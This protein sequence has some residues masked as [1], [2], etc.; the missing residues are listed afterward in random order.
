MPYGGGSVATSSGPQ[1]S[2]STVATFPW[3]PETGNADLMLQNIN[4]GTFPALGMSTS[5]GWNE[6]FLP[7]EYP[8]EYP[9]LGLS[10]NGDFSCDEDFFANNFLPGPSRVASNTEEVFEELSQRVRDYPKKILQRDFWSPFIHHSLYR[11]A[12]GGMAEPLGTALACA[13]AYDSCV[14]SSSSFINTMINTQREKLIRATCSYVDQPETCLAALHAVRV[15]QILSSLD[16]RSRTTGPVEADR[17]Q[18]GSGLAA[19]FHIS[20]LLKMTRRL[21]SLYKEAVTSDTE[22]DWSRWKFAESLRRCVFFV[23]LINV[24]AA[25]CRRFHFDYFEPLDDALILEMPLP[26]T[27]QTWRASNEAQW[28]ICR[29]DTQLVRPAPTLQKLMEIDDAGQ[30]DRATLTPLTRIILACAR[31]NLEADWRDG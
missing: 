20:F 30:L 14:E 29:E 18:T 28:Q 7:E 2:S 26:T 5:L 9:R 16:D 6:S 12:Q 31:V 17:P 11:C 15:Y 8:S 23:N 25:R 19:E 3:S 13:S 10:P 1:D 24:L 4:D 21:C 22:T 27:E